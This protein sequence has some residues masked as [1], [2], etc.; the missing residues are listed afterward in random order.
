MSFVS[1]VIVNYRSG[2]LLDGCLESV[3][4]ALDGLK[5]EIL[6]VNNDSV[7]NLAPVS[8]RAWPNTRIIQNTSNLGFG[9]AANRG[10]RQSRGDSLLLLNPDV[11]VLPGS[12]EALVK[13]L[14]K[15]PSAAL[16]LPRLQ[17]PDGSLQY[18]CRRFYDY[19][20]LIA[21]RG[22]WKRLFSENAKVRW[23]L[24][25]DWD[26]RSLSPVDW[27]LGAAM[28][29]RR[30]AIRES[31]LFDERF[32]L[33]FEDVD[34]CLRMRRAGWEILYEPASVMVHA[35]Q[36]DS[37]GTLSLNAKWHHLLSLMKFLWK[38]RFRL[39]RQVKAAV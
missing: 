20:T 2:K 26:H 32:F 22:P 33:Y 15:Y 14:R 24:M 10:V 23:H 9:A 21:R 25:K 6:I 11:R 4:Q 1:V 3:T 13:T 5:F 28:L 34:L 36:R 27:G 17:N 8:A 7:Q 39:S 29:V 12:I 37:A 31:T 16:V 35:H 18:S 38:L 19:G 30:E